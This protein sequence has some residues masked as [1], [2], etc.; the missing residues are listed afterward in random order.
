MEGSTLTDTSRGGA[1]GAAGAAARFAAE[2]CGEARIGL[3]CMGLTGI[4]GFVARERAIDTLHAALDRGVR[5]FDTAAL[6][7][8]GAN[9]ELLGEVLGHRRNIV[10]VT[11]FGLYEQADG[12]L[13]R[14][15]SPGSIRASVEASLR[16]VRRECLDLVLQHRPDPAVPDCAVA[17]TVSVLVK[18]GKVAAFGLS[19]TP[20]ERLKAWPPT[21]PVSAVQNELSLCAPEAG[22]EPQSAM[23]AGAVFMA[24]APL[25]RGLLAGS[26]P[27][28][29]GDL[30]LRMPGFVNLGEG[31]TA[32]QM[33]TLDGVARRRAVPAARV[34]LAWLLARSSNVVAIPGCRSPSQVEDALG[35]DMRL[36]SQEVSELDRALGAPAAPSHRP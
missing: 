32:R 18:E 28:S 2:L 31:G 8:S 34:A 16:R 19:G 30:R 29:H 17:E 11:K 27:G 33:A 4:Y 14:D 36:T 22:D 13:A 10:I 25:G 35:G 20:I 24:Y 5:L 15:S 21:L 23:A 12:S 6:Y 1:G 7:A 3:G 26:R 9:E